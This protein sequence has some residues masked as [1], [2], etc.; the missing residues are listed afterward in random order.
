MNREPIGFDQGT[1]N[2]IA[3]RE[4]VYGLIRIGHSWNRTSDILSIIDRHTRGVESKFVPN[5]NTVFAEHTSRPSLDHRKVRERKGLNVFHC[6]NLLSSLT[7]FTEDEA[8]KITSEL[9]R[10]LPL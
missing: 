5:K 1:W 4:S 7:F 8:A 10:S 6:L 2:D 3:L 9:Q